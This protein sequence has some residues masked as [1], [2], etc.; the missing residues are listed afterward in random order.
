MS[1]KLRLARMGNKKR[2]FYRIVAVN[3]AARRDGRPLEFL[4]FYNPMVNPAEV[5]IDTAK[6]QKWLD[7]GAEPTDTVRALLKKQAG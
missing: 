2:A 6:V 1:V 3:S 4:G 5:K 7:Q